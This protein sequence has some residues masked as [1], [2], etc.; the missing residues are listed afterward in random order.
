MEKNEID[1]LIHLLDDPDSEIYSHVKEKLVSIGKHVIPTLETAWEES[2][3]P[4]LQERI[5]YIIHKI[6]FDGLLDDFR[7]WKKSEEPKLFEGAMLVAKYRYPELDVDELRY[8]LDEIKRAI[9]LEQNYNLTPIEQINVFNHVFYTIE[10]FAGK[11][12][13][14]L[15]PNNFFLNTVLESHT[16]NSLSLGIIYL[17]IARELDIPV[18]G[19]NLPRHFILAYTKSFISPYTSSK[20]KQSNVIFYIN[21]LNK[22]AIF[23]RNEIQS[24]LKKMELED[25]AAYFSPC[26]DGLVVQLLM[27]NLIQAYQDEY[28][29]D[30]V[31]ELQLLLNILLK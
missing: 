8:Q 22:G 2:M 14:N 26:S 9:W 31:E 19:V 1:A 4:N 28:D 27:E 6:Q 18:Y 23:T 29:H 15:N 20:E 16:G 24:Y 25:D 13:T 17:I 10:G 5:E 11:A 30:K 21:P 12:I 7:Q 3:N